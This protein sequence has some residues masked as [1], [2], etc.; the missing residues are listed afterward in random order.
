MNL[1]KLLIVFLL[2]LCSSC[3]Q[4]EFHYDGPKEFH[5]S[6]IGGSEKIVEV[7]GMAPFY[8]WGLVPGTMKVN[9]DNEFFMLGANNPSMVKIESNTTALS[10]FYSIVTFGIYFPQSYKISVYSMSGITR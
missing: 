1:S 8:F 9:L 7:D 3:A 6:S 5:V 4:L 2:L 10:L